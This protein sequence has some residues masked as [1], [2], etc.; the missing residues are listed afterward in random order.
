MTYELK[1]G[2]LTVRYDPAAAPLSVTARS[3]KQIL[4]RILS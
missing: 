4:H 3:S 1:N 2:K